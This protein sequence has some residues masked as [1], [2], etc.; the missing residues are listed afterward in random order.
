MNFNWTDE[1]LDF[2]QKVVEF[3]QENLN[4]GVRSNDREGVFPREKWERCA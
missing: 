4:K 2:K 1:Q 3:A